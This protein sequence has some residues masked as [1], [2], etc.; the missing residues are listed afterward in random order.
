MTKFNNNNDNEFIT[1]DN[2]HIFLFRL[3]DDNKLIIV[4]HSYLKDIENLHKLNENKIYFLI[5]VKNLIFMKTLI[6]I[7][8]SQFFIKFKI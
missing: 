8:I 7:L 4:A 3:T 1:C 6:I 2:G 5:L